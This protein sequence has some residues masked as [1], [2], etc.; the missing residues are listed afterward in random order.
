[1]TMFMTILGIAGAALMVGMYAFLQQGRL[2][3]QSITYYA[4]N[5]IGALLILISL[6][7]D[8]D[9]A[10]LGGIALEACWILISIMGIARASKL[11]VSK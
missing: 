3:A 11:R 9:S 2:N 8:F 6:S 10:D 4:V 1:M 5:G 7:Y